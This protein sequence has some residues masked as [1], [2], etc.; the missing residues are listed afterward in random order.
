MR[1]ELERLPPDIRRALDPDQHPDPLVGAGVLL[2]A[3][4]QLCKDRLAHRPALVKLGGAEEAQEARLDLASRCAFMFTYMMQTRGSRL[5]QSRM[6][7][8]VRSR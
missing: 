8:R 4:V 6:V 1:A 5:R 7:P 2:L 3:L